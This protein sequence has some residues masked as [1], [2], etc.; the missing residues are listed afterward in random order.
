MQTL[1]T[2]KDLDLEAAAAA[3]AA[4]G[5]FVDLRPVDEYLDVH[6]PASLALVYEFGPGLPSRARDCLPLDLPIVLLPDTASDLGN[7]AASLRGKGFSVLGALR[8]G[9]RAW[10][11][12]FGHP[13]STELATAPPK[14][15]FILDVG[16]PGATPPDDAT[17]IPAEQLWNRIDEVDAPRVAIV[18]G[19]GIRAA[20]AIGILERAGIRD[21]SFI[22]SRA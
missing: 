11:D 5:A 20:L 2:L 15:A 10:A 1:T 8:D 6:I 16:D 19:Y 9:L 17:T 3:V 14:D 21:I 13:A 7:A 4:G 18:A 12:R 22:R